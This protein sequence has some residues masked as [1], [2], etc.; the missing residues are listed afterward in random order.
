M[1]FLSLFLWKIKRL[2]P[3]KSFRHL[4]KRHFI[5]ATINSVIFDRATE[6]NKAH[7]RTFVECFESTL[8]LRGESVNHALNAL[9]AQGFIL[10]RS[11]LMRWKKGQLPNYNSLQFNILAQYAGFP[12]F[13]EMLTAP[14]VESEDRK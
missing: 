10:H 4:T 11:T 14:Q 9:R 8:R 6:V 5:N 7:C 13:I 3:L 2:P 1:N 12:S